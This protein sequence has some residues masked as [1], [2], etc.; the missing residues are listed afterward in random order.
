M[1][2]GLWDFKSGVKGDAFISHLCDSELWDKKSSVS[3]LHHI[4]FPRNTM[5][6]FDYYHLMQFSSSYVKNPQDSYRTRA[7]VVQDYDPY[8]QCKCRVCIL[9]PFADNAFRSAMLMNLRRAFIVTEKEIMKDH[10]CDT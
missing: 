9:R 1:L 3:H 2:W 8:V 7:I 6:F 10:C 4:T 5:K